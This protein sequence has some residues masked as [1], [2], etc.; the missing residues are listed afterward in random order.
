M[1]CLMLLTA[2]LVEKI[3]QNTDCV[4]VKLKEEGTQTFNL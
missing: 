4:I 3:K 2:P 1:H